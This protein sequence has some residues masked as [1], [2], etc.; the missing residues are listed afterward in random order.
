MKKHRA[1]PIGGALCLINKFLTLFN[2]LGEI[3][4]EIYNKNEKMKW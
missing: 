4:G 1:L 2:F 3:I